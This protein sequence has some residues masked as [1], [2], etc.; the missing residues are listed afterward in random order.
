MCVIMIVTTRTFVEGI[1]FTGENPKFTIRS[2]AIGLPPDFETVILPTLND[3]IKQGFNREI[4]NNINSRIRRFSSEPEKFI[5]AWGDSS[6]FSSDGATQ[7]NYAGYDLFAFTLGPMIGFALPPNLSGVIDEITA[8]G[9]KALDFFG[10]HDDLYFGANPQILSAQI[11][12]NT[13]RFLPIN[14]LYLGL[15]IGFM[16]LD[17]VNF[18]PVSISFN[19]FSI[20]ITANYQII[21]QQKYAS[22]LVLWRGLNVGTGFLYQGTK[23][24]LGMA[25]ETIVVK[26]DGD[27]ISGVTFKDTVLNIDPTLAFSMETDTLTI[28]LEA[29]TSVKLLHFLNLALGLGVDLGF[30]RSKINTN[31]DVDVKVP[32]Y[33]SEKLELLSDGYL[34]TN[35]G[36]ERPPFAFNLKLM[37]GVGF[38]LGPVII[39]VPISYYPI[40]NGFSAGITLGVAF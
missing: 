18:D 34:S 5:R 6:V 28:P 29:I 26:V 15:R 3:Q 1:E 19:N 12:L 22:G 7:R 36:G 10:K 31:I 13:S 40:T 38:S 32:S 14:N 23:L 4:N 8:E 16:N 25:I 39:D 20:G 24:N 2:G 17:N 21:P 11:G 27:T 9:D 30:G 35:L 33:D 37:S